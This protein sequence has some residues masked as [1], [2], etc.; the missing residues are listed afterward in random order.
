M[1]DQILTL[2]NAGFTRDE[3]TAIL[4]Q[5]RAGS[6]AVA[7]SPVPA[8]PDHV[9]VPAAVD[10]PAGSGAVP[11]PAGSAPALDAAGI[12]RAIE[13]M[14]R[15]LIA[16][17]QKAQIGGSSAPAPIDPNAQM[18]AITAQIINPTYKKEAGNNG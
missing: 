17:M 1:L 12:T 2:I 7:N 16:A 4:N 13:D 9:S 15:H 6:D 3:I 8:E 5:E 11:A 10:A 14:G 18:D